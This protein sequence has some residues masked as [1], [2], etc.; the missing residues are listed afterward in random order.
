VDFLIVLIELLSLGVT[1]EALQANIGSKSSIS[2]QR[3]SVGRKF[4]V[5]GVDPTYHSSL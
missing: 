3:G 4:Q 1:V 5:E 2:L